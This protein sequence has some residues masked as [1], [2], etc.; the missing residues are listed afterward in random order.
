LSPEEIAVLTK[1]VELGVPW[2][3]DEPAG[4]A[5]SDKVFNLEARRKARW[6]WQPVKPQTPSA[7]KDADWP[8][9]P[10]DRF[11]LAR[12]EEKGLAPAKPADRPA[13]IR[14]AHFDLIGLPPTAE[15]V[16]A[17]VNDPSSKAFEKV[18][19]RLLDSPHF[20]ERW[21]RHWMDLVRY[22][23]TFGHEF[24]YPIP[25]ATLYR[26]YLIRALNADVPYNQLVVEHLA[27]DLLAEPRQHP[28][29]GYNESIIGTGFWWFGEATHAPVDVKGDE[30]GRVDNQI[31][32]MTKTFLG[33]TVACAR[34]HDHKFDAISTKDYYALAG[35]L[36]SSRRQEAMLD[37][38]GKI[39]KAA[40]HR[41]AGPLPA[42]SRGVAARFV[43]Q[44]GHGRNQ[45]ESRRGASRAVGEGPVERGGEEADS[46]IATNC[47]SR[48]SG[49]AAA[50]GRFRSGSQEVCRPSQTSCR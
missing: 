39:A 15:E 10:L 34:C 7:V 11:I 28:T 18:V 37:P 23:E 16:E 31:D 40:A 14:R 41:D 6:C 22:A 21:A 13:L 50:C 1:W 36:K 24:D 46:P 47:R 44:R 17:F 9:Q 35:Y 4:T 12:L 33:L 43:G 26:D 2:P 42:G 8:R 27:G 5:G 19:D 48:Q 3:K 25:H 30:A 38:H 32:V 29:D 45:G 20:G 49:R